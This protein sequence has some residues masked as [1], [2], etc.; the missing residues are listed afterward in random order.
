MAIS[1]GSNEDNHST[2]AS[3]VDNAKQKVSY[4]NYSMFLRTSVLLN[5]EATSCI[6]FK[7]PEEGCCERPA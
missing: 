3:K 5:T 7:L 6:M 4:K 2:H 1:A